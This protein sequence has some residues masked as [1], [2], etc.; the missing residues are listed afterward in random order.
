MTPVDTQGCGNTFVANTPECIRQTA[1][2][3]TLSTSLSAG[4]QGIRGSAAL[5]SDGNFT[6]AALS[7]GSLLRTGCIGSWDPGK[8]VLQIECGGRNNTQ[9]CVV[10][11]TR[12]TATC[13]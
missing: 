7:E 13:N 11:L 3:I 2:T 5:Q 12:T 9:T 6:G 8:S 10:A 4:A 1:C